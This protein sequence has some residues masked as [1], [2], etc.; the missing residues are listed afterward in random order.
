MKAPPC[1]VRPDPR[2]RPPTN[3]PCTARLPISTPERRPS[4]PCAPAALATVIN[5]INTAL[6]TVGMKIDSTESAPGS[7]KH[8][9]I[10]DTGTEHCLMATEYAQPELEL[11]AKIVEATID[12]PSGA[13]NQMEA[14]NLR[15]SKLGARAAERV[16]ERLVEQTWLAHGATRRQARRGADADDADAE[17]ATAPA[18]G[19][20][21]G[22]GVRSF[23]DLKAYLAEAV[24]VPGAPTIDRVA[25]ETEG[26]A[27]LQPGEAR[28]HFTPPT[29]ETH[30]IIGY[31]GAQPKPRG[32]RTATASSDRVPR[33]C[34][35]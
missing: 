12:S 17:G 5:Q 27:S 7:A 19:G 14:V 4:P 15:S 9:G 35:Q 30:A 2:T 18:Y 20:G 3:H 26:D 23:I 10:V 13:I 31:V 22:L 1:R 11:F 29:G 33:R 21:L 16:I 32:R 8:W 6:E 25:F 34:S 24:P 28:V